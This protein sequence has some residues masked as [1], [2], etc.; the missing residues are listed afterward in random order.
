MMVGYGLEG[1]C[2]HG[3]EPTDSIKFKNSWVAE[4]LM[5]SHEELSSMELAGY[6]VCPTLSTDLYQKWTAGCK[7]NWS[8][9]ILKC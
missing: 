2:E 4:W 5:A 9:E 7:H 8:K 6:S 1:S 3:N